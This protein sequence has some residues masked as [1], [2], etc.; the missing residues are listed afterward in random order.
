MM[1][2]MMMMM[3]M[4]MMVIITIIIF[5]SLII[6]GV[7]SVVINISCLFLKFRLAFILAVMIS[8]MEMWGEG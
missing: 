8:R 1:I 2:T 4:M 7:L 5:I 3:M 6:I